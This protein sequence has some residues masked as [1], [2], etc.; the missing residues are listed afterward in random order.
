[1]ND[2]KTKQKMTNAET[3]D[4]MHQN[5]ESIEKKTYLKYQLTKDSLTMRHTLRDIAE[6]KLKPK[7]QF[8]NPKSNL[9]L[10]PIP[11]PIPISISNPRSI[12]NLKQ[13]NESITTRISQ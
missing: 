12:S 11:I 10:I 4:E 3:C 9:E 6:T 1:M 5:P 2:H 7:D 8:S 13:I